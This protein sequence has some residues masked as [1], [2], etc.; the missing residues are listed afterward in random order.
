[1]KELFKITNKKI[2]IITYFISAIYY[3]CE[4]GCSFA[5]AY[6]ATAPFTTDKIIFLSISLA[7]LYI[8]M[9]CSNWLSSFIDCTIYPKLEINIQKYYFNKIQSITAKKVSEIHTGYI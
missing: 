2:I 8:L 4:Y 3:A 7:V 9:L 6:F 1:M 5:L